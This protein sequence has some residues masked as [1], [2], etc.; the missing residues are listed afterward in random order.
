MLKMEQR[1]HFH[2][3]TG[4]GIKLEYISHNMITRLVKLCELL[5]GYIAFYI[6]FSLFVSRTTVLGVGRIER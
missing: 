5:K 3:K 6:Y 2:T 1:D 4:T